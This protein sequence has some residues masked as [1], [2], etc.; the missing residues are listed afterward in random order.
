MRGNGTCQTR[1]IFDW[2]LEDAFSR[3]GLLYVIAG[4]IPMLWGCAGKS[5][6]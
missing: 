3:Y 1:Q 5:L 2:K 6:Q 4:A